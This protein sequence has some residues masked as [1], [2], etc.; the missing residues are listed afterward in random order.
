M[1]RMTD[2]KLA[3]TNADEM[4]ATH[5]WVLVIET[6]EYNQYVFPCTS[7]EI[8]VGYLYAFVRRQW[9]R[10]LGGPEHLSAEWLA[11]PDEMV[12]AYFEDTGEA[13][14]YDVYPLHAAFDPDYHPEEAAYL[15]QA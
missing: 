7:R 13:Y 9:E 12:K 11:D 5:I 14:H 6:N 8:A 4:D 10:L 1:T 3:R 2:A 15:S